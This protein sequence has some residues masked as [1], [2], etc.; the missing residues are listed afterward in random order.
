MNI[1]LVSEHLSLL[2]GL[3]RKEVIDLLFNIGHTQKEFAK[4]LGLTHL[5]GSRKR[6]VIAKENKR[7][8]IG[9][10]NG[11][12]PSKTLTLLKGH[13][14]T[15]NSYE[16]HILFTLVES[17]SILPTTRS[18]LKELLNYKIVASTDKI[19]ELNDCAICS[20]PTKNTICMS[21]KPRLLGYLNYRRESFSVPIN[22]LNFNIR[23]EIS[24][25]D[26]FEFPWYD[27]RISKT[28]GTITCI[29]V[30]E[31]AEGFAAIEYEL[32]FVD[33]QKTIS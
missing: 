5:I 21:C 29:L 20:Y 17:P 8:T 28:D 11:S 27:W 32:P 10:S 6:L 3:N 23:K 15:L 25:K 7:I 12:L 2:H 30:Q 13:K 14:T 18:Q 16:Y 9:E 24:T 26:D 19:D 33:Y 4:L 31:L 22:Y 1:Q